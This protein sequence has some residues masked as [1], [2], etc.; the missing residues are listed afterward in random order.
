MISSLKS[1]Q[2]RLKTAKKKVVPTLLGAHS[3]QKLVEIHKALKIILPITAGPGSTDVDPFRV[4][5][6]AE[7][8]IDL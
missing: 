2:K 8:E 1:A 7:A 5:D 6:E 3:T 4:F